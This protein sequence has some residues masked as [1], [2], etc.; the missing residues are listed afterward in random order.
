MNL[1]KT[2]SV[3]LLGLDKDPLSVIYQRANVG[4]GPATEPGVPKLIQAV[5]SRNFPNK[6]CSSLASGT[7]SDRSM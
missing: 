1:L 5:F 4:K 3:G 7:C 2:G 6:A